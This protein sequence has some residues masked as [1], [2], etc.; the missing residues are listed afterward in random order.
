MA[1]SEVAAT[2]ANY[3]APRVVAQATEKFTIANER[4]PARKRAI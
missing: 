2:Q 4:N 3:L 1:A